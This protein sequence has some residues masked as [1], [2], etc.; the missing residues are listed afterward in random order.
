MQDAE[1]NWQFD[2]YAFAE[3]A[4]G[5]TLSLLAWHYHKQ[6][7]SLMLLAWTLTSCTSFCP[8]LRLATVQQTHIITG[9]TLIVAHMYLCS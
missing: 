7:G 3:A 4:P 1:E 2:V 5:K 6:G 9:Q 8:R